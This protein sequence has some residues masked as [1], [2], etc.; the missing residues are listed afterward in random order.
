ML[1]FVKSD[2]FRRLCAALVGVAL[3]YLNQKLGLSI[4][5]EQVIAGMVFVGGYI[6]Q[7]AVN[8]M[9]AR[10]VEAGAAAVVAAQPQTP[11]AGLAEAPKP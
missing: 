5:P 9:H 11:A 3:P 2:T 6:A 1:D 4:P 7:S 10:S 8:S